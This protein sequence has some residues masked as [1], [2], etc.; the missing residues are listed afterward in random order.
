M[1]DTKQIE[2]ALI[3][4]SI[5]A[6]RKANNLTQEELANRCGYSIRNLRRIENYGTASIDV[7]N[8]F[9]LIFKVKA[10]DILNGCFL[11]TKSAIVQAIADFLSIIPLGNRQ[12]RISSYTFYFNLLFIHMHFRLNYKELLY[13]F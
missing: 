12:H 10:I 5:K 4:K 2:I 3:G 1:N 7:I 13:N 9:A 11:K 6:L 8:T